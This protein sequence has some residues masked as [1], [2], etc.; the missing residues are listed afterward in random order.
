MPPLLCSSLLE[1]APARRGKKA[2]QAI[3]SSLLLLGLETVVR[4]HKKWQLGH[5]VQVLSGNPLHANAEIQEDSE[6]ELRLASKL[7]DSLTDLSI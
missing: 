6:L 2:C 3:P 7:A 5:T 1:A 4:S